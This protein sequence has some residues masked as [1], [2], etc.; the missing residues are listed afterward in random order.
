[1][2]QRMHAGFLLFALVL[3]WPLT[4]PAAEP[5][6]GFLVIAP[7]RGFLGNQE[8]VT[9]VQEFKKAYPAALGL[10]GREYTGVE[11][12]Y[13]VYLTRAVQELKKAGATQV[14]AVPLFL[15]EADP[16]LK[17]ATSTLPA[18]T[19]GLPIRWAPAMAGSYLIGQA[20]MDRVEALSQHPEQ[21]RLI[22]IGIGATDEASETAIRADLEKLLSY[23]KRYKHFREAEV[24]VYYDRDAEGAEKKNQDIKAH[25]LA[26]IAKQG[27][28]LVVPAFIGP[29]FD[30]SMAMTAWLGKQF[31]GL[32]VA[33]QGA[34][35]LPHPN[36]LLWLKKTANRYIPVSPQEV[37]V[38]IMPHGSTQP[39]NDAAERT[40]EPLKT[41]YKI[42][43]AYG[44]GD[45]TIIQDAVSRLE[46]QGVKR[47]VFV[48]MY[49]LERQMK[50]LTDYILGL[51]DS[52]TPSGH[53]GGHGHDAVF[54]PQIRSSALFSTFGGYTENFRP[55]ASVLCDRIVEV[56]KDPAKETVVLLAHGSNTDEDNNHWLS[57][58]K[59]NADW[60]KKDPRCAPFKTIK[61]ATVRE[62]WPEQREKAVA[63]VRKMIEDDAKT[64]RVLV[65]ANRMYG[66]GP[67]KK[68][69]K[70]LEYVLNEKGFAGPVL[71]R[72]LEEGIAEV[73]TALARAMDGADRVAER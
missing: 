25:V 45:P 29:K 50:P 44:M 7:D 33:Y 5:K 15:S 43:M 40:I 36:V 1:M 2:N 18:Y 56:S 54:P 27:R 41:K 49:E 69:L 62:D 23:V 3:I 63:E 32:N 30:R 19:G 67:Y 34:E 61:A 38:V 58:I 72:W 14:V 64:G 70:G 59:A 11:G 47:I 24:V 20:V 68:M 6:A 16:V 46:Q 51:A 57:V 65:I 4:A 21:E 31:K 26:Q 52:P 22:L 8:A 71:T 35:L 37:G 28:T 13:A 53:T 9:L 42:E 39:W 66:S 12:E 55:I 73:A 10:I 17:R 60:V 48:R